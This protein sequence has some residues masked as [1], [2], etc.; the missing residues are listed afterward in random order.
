VL[1]RRRILLCAV[2]AGALSVLPGALS[3]QVRGIVVD[4]ESHAIEDAVVELWSSTDRIAILRTSASG[5]FQFDHNYSQLIAGLVIRRIGFRPI[6]FSI[7]ATIDPVQ[8]R[9]E[10]LPSQLSEVTIAT[11]RGCPEKDEAPARAIIIQAQARYSHETDSVGIATSFQGSIDF[12]PAQPTL[13]PLET[14]QFTPGDRGSAGLSRQQ[15]NGHVSS[16][17]YA[18]PSG[19]DLT[20][21]YQEYEYP[22]LESDFAGHFADSLFSKLHAFHVE[23]VSNQETRIMFCGLRRKGPYMDG[24]ITLRADSSFERAAWSFHTQRPDELAGG[25]VV[26][27]PLGGT[28]SPLVAATGLFWRKEVGGNYFV[29]VENFL[30]WSIGTSSAIPP[31]NQ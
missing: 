27:V 31:L 5:H 12:S 7:A 22:L 14:S 6:S 30:H 3:A 21:K 20:G 16:H 10:G 9:M 8:V 23:S 19:G 1:S 26:F 29:E 28:S 18:W 24:V 15:W 25:E 11:A 13:P 4:Q 17:G 2:L